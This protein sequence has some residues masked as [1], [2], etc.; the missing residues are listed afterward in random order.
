M[1]SV[2]GDVYNGFSWGAGLNVGLGSASKGR[3]DG[4]ERVV[5]C[6]FVDAHEFAVGLA[7]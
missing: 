7:F 4:S 3:L 5:E 2:D 6:F 1:S